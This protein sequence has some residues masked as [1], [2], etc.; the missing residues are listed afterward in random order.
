MNRIA[1]AVPK[2]LLLLVLFLFLT[3]SA[4]SAV[5][6][7]TATFTL[8]VTSDP[9]GLTDIIINTNITPDAPITA[10]DGYSET[11]T[12]A[13]PDDGTAWLYFAVQT[14]VPFHT[15]EITCTGSDMIELDGIIVRVLVSGGEAVD[16][17]FANTHVRG[18]I[19]VVQ[20]TDP[21]GI[22][23]FLYT[24][25][26]DNPFTLNDGEQMVYELPSGQPYTIFQETPAGSELEISCNSGNVT[27]LDDGV[28]V[29]LE[30]DDNVIC[31][32]TNTGDING[33]P[34]C[35]GYEA[36][37]YVDATGIIVGGPDDGATY[38]G[39]LQ[40]GNK[41]D[42]I[43][44]TSD[45]DIINGGNGTDLICAGAGND[46]VSGNNGD[47]IVY[48]GGGDDIVN[49]NNG[50]DTLYGEDGDD[51]LMGDRGDDLLDG[52]IGTD[53]LDG[54]KGDNTLLNGE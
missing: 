2:P 9:T 36:T 40:G 43:V 27:I 38:A 33:V 6:A 26:F 28:T 48:A 7:G 21:A 18:S 12:I 5:S 53:M 16:C 3:W 25:N 37:I 50:D 44:G 52:G 11:F 17:T 24:P 22:G 34:Q 1:A 15:L 20:D 42:V 13:T 41:A 8:N 14:E 51:Y 23:G 32:F 29:N 49:G 54:G 47:D 31:T 35:N 46:T 39:T 19:T 4:T 10:F 30:T 45:S